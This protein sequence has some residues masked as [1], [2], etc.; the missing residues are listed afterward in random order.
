MASMSDMF[1]ADVRVLGLRLAKR[2]G[3]RGQGRFCAIYFNTA[4][5]HVNAASCIAAVKVCST[6][7]VVV[8]SR[9]EAP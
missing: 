4:S 3:K 2:L 1:D 9:S 7:H 6:G 5:S 8:T